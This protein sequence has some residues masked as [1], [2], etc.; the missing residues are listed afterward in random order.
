MHPSANA[1]AMKHLKLIG[2]R[3][4][5]AEALLLA[6]NHPAA[7]RT[8]LEARRLGGQ[9]MVVLIVDCLRRALAS[10]NSPDRRTRETCVDEFVRLVGL[11]GSTLCL[12]CRRR[13]V[14]RPKEE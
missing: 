9:T 13:V 10:V 6:G 2:Q 12:A 4:A 7:I 11:A 14:A 8:L 3:V 5:A 1:E